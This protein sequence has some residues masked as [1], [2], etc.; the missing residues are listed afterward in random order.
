RTGGQGGDRTPPRIP[1]AFFPLLRVGRSGV[2]KLELSERATVTIRFE[3]KL[4]GRRKA[5]RCV[6]PSRAPHGRR[7]ARLSLFGTQTR[8]GVAGRD[9]LTI[10]GRIGRRTLPAGRYRITVRAK[11]DAGNVSKPVTVT[12]DVVVSARPRKVAGVL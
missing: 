6:Q 7:C 9:R 12:T 5:G 1:H 4:A 10:G 3:R 2:L 8:N 11:D